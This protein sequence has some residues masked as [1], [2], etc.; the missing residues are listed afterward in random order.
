MIRR[1]PRSTRTD[2]LFPYTTL[3]RST[4]VEKDAAAAAIVGDPAV[5]RKRRPRLRAVGIGQAI[6]EGKQRRPVMSGRCRPGRRQAPLKVEGNRA[7][8]AGKQQVGD[9]GAFGPR[10]PGGERKSGVEGKRVAERV[11][12]GGRLGLKKKKK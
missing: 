10:Q 12:L 9:A 6:A 4:L 8:L 11:D 7:V 1:P 2:T 5:L 3:F